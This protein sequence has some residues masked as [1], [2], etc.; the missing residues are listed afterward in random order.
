M[1]D[2]DL[3]DEDDL[4]EALNCHKVSRHMSIQQEL[5]FCEE[6]GMMVE[7]QDHENFKIMATDERLQAIGDVKVRVENKEG[8]EKKEDDESSEV[9]GLSDTGSESS[10]VT[11]QLA[12]KN[13]FKK[14]RILKLKL[15]TLGGIMNSKTFLYAVPIYHQ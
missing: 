3:G 11:H 4:I 10:F 2:E 14:I 12:R 9:L 7:E 8:E 13:K 6:N 15:N 1:S 5:Q